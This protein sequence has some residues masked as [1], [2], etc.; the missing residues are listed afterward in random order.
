MTKTHEQTGAG[1]TTDSAESGDIHAEQFG[2]KRIRE[3]YRRGMYD[4]ETPDFPVSY[5]EL[6]DAAFEQMSENAKACVHGG[7]GTEETFERNK[8]FSRWRIV[9]RMLRG[10]ADRDFSV[11]VFGTEHEYPLMVTPLGVQTLL[12]EEGETATA[13]ACEDLNVP[14]VLSSLS[15]TPLEEVAET[16]GDTAKWFQFYWSSDR[17][18]AADGERPVEPPRLSQR[19]TARGDGASLVGRDRAIPP[20]PRLR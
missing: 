9:P 10:V 16:L 13:R 2:V 1:E 11:D 7:A 15:S 4:G 17:E 18:V 19:P 5:E 20:Q 3:A 6:R 12:H 14:F 8:D